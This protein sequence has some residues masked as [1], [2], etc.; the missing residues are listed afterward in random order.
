M[1]PSI[2]L[3]NDLVAWQLEDGSFIASY[4]PA[5]EVTHPQ[6][7]ISLQFSSHQCGKAVDTRKLAGIVSTGIMGHH[8]GSSQYSK[9]FRDSQRHGL[10]LATSHVLQMEM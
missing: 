4:G 8:L 7:S 10:N 3:C 1:N 6:Y 5:F 2:D 9:I